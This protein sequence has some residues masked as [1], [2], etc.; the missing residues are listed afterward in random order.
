MKKD[1]QIT[2]RIFN[3]MHELE[4]VNGRYHRNKKA[5]QIELNALKWVLDEKL[6]SMELTYIIMQIT[7]K[8]FGLPEN[9][10]FESLASRKK[11]DT[12]PRYFAMKLI[13]DNTRVNIQQLSRLF[14]KNRHTVE[15]NLKTINNLLDVYKD[16]R[17][18]YESV[19]TQ[20]VEFKKSIT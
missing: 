14:K 8:S 12:Y 11:K 6:T 7:S 1:T 20:V 18:K 15:Y 13:I 9:N 10:V 2:A 5:L 3:L 16:L 19:E 4:K 17:A